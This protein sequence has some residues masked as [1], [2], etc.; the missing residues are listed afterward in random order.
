M[1]HRK[2][3]PVLEFEAVEC[4]CILPVLSLRFGAGTAG[5]RGGTAQAKRRQLAEARRRL[6]EQTALYDWLT[7]WILNH[8]RAVKR[9]EMLAIKKFV[10]RK[11]LVRRMFG[12]WV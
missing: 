12:V 10:A 3:N 2:R 7:D 5:R 6:A 9:T 8:N 1:W 4:L 11:K